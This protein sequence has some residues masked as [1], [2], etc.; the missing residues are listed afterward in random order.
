M[1]TKIIMMKITIMPIVVIKTL[2]DGHHSACDYMN[3][4]QRGIS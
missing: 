4:K 2:L 1:L 3:Y